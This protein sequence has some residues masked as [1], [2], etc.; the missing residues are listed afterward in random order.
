MALP[1]EAA[2]AMDGWQK[3]D[4][5]VGAERA[6]LDFRTLEPSSLLEDLGRHQLLVLRDQT[7]TPES[8]STAAARLGELDAYPFAEGLPEA[9]KVVRLLKEPADSSNFGG[10]WHTDT[11]YALE[12]PRITLL[13]AVEV[14]RIGGDTL[15]ADA[16]GAFERL[17]D[18]FKTMLRGLTGHNTASLVHSDSGGYADVAGESVTLKESQVPTDAEHPLVIVNP[19]SGREALY[20]SLIHTSHFL[21]LTRLESLP[22]LEQLHGIITAPEN[23]TRLRWRPGTLALWD[24][25]AL[26]HYPLND[27]PG[28]RREMHRIILKGDVP[29]AATSRLR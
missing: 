18:G 28:E 22:L 16:V 12:P 8:F 3:L 13:Y 5:A 4:G 2:D 20:F 26:Q 29:L 25:R 19:L 7:L 10:A 1:P 23:V 11:A 21:G 15:F 17:S 27:Y 24:N 6:D 9:P 14:P